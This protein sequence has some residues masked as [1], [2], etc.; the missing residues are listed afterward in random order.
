MKSKSLLG[1]WFSSLRKTGDKKMTKTFEEHLQ[2][3]TVIDSQEA[4]A[5]IEEGEKFILFL[6]RETCPFCQK[7]MPKLS[8]VVSEN[9]LEAYFINTQDFSDVQGI[10]EL[11]EKYSVKTVPG[12][13]VAENRDVKVVCDSSLSVEEILAFVK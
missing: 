9:N 7:F 4:F 5:K 12:L 2:N 1:R 10:E 11:R 8:E 3:F 6:G 13:L